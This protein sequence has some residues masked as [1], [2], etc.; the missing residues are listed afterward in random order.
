MN[1]ATPSIAFATRI[2]YWVVFLATLMAITLYLDRICFSSLERS[3]IRDLQ[4]TDGDSAWLLSIFFWTYALG[5]VPAG[6]LSDRFGSRHMLALYILGW[7]A[8]TGLMGVASSFF[9][10]FL[11]R[12]GCGLAQ[13]GAYPTAAL[14][15]SRWM[16]FSARGTASG[17]VSTGGRI[18]GV[19]APVLTEYLFLAFAFSQEAWRPVLWI[20]G[21]VG[22][23]VAAW[24]WLGV[25]DR[26]QEHPHCN[27][28]E[29]DAIEAGRPTTAS[30][31]HGLAGALPIRYMLSNF[32]LWCACFMQFG[33]NFGWVFLITLLP[34]YLTEAHQVPLGPRGLM[35]SLPI[36][37][38]MGGMLMGG[39]LTDRLT[40][41]LGLRWGR[42][43]PMAVSRFCAMT[44]FLVSLLLDS[45][46][47][48]TAA[49]CFVAV[50]TDLGTA[51]LWAFKQDVGGRYVGSILGWGNMFG[52]MGA[53]TS[54]LVLNWVV[55]EA[56]WSY[57]FV[58]C[59]MAFCV[60]GVAALGV[61]ATRPIVPPGMVTPAELEVGITVL[62]PDGP[63]R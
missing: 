9:E 47:A 16:P 6:W 46:W 44:A 37:V 28:E 18:G 23:G 22:V 38:G 45:P 43:L 33:T 58:A 50:S 8:F 30:S 39:W 52:N 63:G 1:E 40:R 14:M 35:T 19:L 48:V 62:K 17:I 34:R 21:I 2:R 10:L 32:S 60:A 29:I 5:Q 42:R 53:A 13:A 24:F 15:I 11:F 25:R 12:A 36:F 41:A 54:P 27:L 31:P 51:S 49:F 59:A 61:D 55:S 7:S 57:A 20:Y 56:G 26:P 3:V 4:L